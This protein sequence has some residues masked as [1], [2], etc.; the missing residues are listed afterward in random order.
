MKRDSE[1]TIQELLKELSELNR[2]DK[3]QIRKLSA[4]EHGVILLDRNNPSDVEWYENDNA[5]DLI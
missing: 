1:K 3:N 2:Q 5:Y 4:N